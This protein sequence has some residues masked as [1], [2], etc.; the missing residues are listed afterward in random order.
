MDKRLIAI[1]IAMAIPGSIY[2][3][4]SMNLKVVDD[5]IWSMIGM[6]VLGVIGIII[7]Q[8]FSTETEKIKKMNEEV[9][10]NQ[11]QL[12]EMQN[13]FLKNVSEK[14]HEEA[15]EHEDDTIIDI[16]NDLIEY[17]RIKSNKNEL[18]SEKFSINKVL[19]EVTGY[20]QGKYK[21]CNKELIIDVDNKIPK[22]LI[23]DSLKLEKVLTSVIE[24]LM[25]EDVKK[26]IKLKI[27]P[28][29][30]KK[31][32]LIIKVSDNGEELT[33]ERIN[34]LFSPNYSDENGK[35]KGLGLF[36]ANE[37]TRIMNGT[38]FFE[39]ISEE[40]KQ[41]EISLPYEEDKTIENNKYILPENIEKKKVFIVDNNYSSALAIKNYF[42]YFDFETK[43][44]SKEEFE[45]APL[46]LVDYDLIL[47]NECLFNLRLMSHLEDIKKDKKIVL[48]E[49]AFK[50]KLSD[51]SKIIDYRLKKPLNQ[52]RIYDFLL[53]I[54]GEEKGAVQEKKILL[55]EISEKLNVNAESFTKFDGMKLLIVE[56]N[57]INQKVLLNLLRYSGIDIKL[58]ENGKE[59]IEQVKNN[60]F[61]IVLM[62]INMPIMDGYKATQIIRQKHKDLT[63]VAFTALALESERKK[64]FEV[65]MNG[66]ITKPI[67]IGKLFNAF[68]IFYETKEDAPQRKIVKKEVKETNIL[69][70]KEGI[71]YSNDNESVYLELLEEYLDAYG[72]ACETFNNLIKEERYGQLKLFITDLRGLTGYIGAKELNYVLTE[73]HQRLLYNKKDLLPNYINEFGE[74]NARLKEIIEDYLS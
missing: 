37:F 43:I 5:S 45:D 4:A 66:V 48:V 70:I 61:D 49:S 46:T 62:D 65:G 3:L 47:L 30:G 54:Y 1:I 20:A 59:A 16:T 34:T 24:F 72:D 38:I 12:E 8:V 40:G 57:L 44:M 42:N 10:D 25:D 26:D 21:D 14:I 67:K 41:F 36:V 33:E 73:I 13:I 69:D 39:N 60:I 63:I 17:L 35:Y 28:E 71:K 64:I 31:K 27:F 32:K 22:Y 9:L 23:G 56:D 74:K 6:F 15:K 7:L 50:E 55:A 2:A 29:E 11:K 51:M 58:A 19:N 52:E 68:D 18:K 53:D